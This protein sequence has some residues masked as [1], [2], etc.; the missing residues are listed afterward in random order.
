VVVHGFEIRKELQL[1]SVAP[2]RAVKMTRDPDARIWI[3]LQASQAGELDMWLERLQV[4]ELTRRICLE[5]GGR[6]G[7]YPLRR[8]ILMLI[9]VHTATDGKRDLAY[10]GFLCRKNLLF[11][12][13]QTPIW[14][15]HQLSELEESENWLPD[16]SIAGLVSAVL[17]DLSLES[18][19]HTVGLRSAI[20]ALEERMDRDP[21]SVE[22]EE[23]L[24]VRSEL[25]DLG[26]LINDQMPSLQ[27]LSATDKPF[28][29]L[30]DARDYLNSALANVQAADRSLDRLD[31]RVGALRLGFQM[32][33]QEETN[34]R[35]NILTVLSAIFLPMT[36]LAGIWGMN[37]EGMPELKVPIGYP[38]A[39]GIMALIGSGMFLFF[40]RHGWFD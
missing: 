3:D 27:A 2:E 24:D 10:V 25:L 16:R 15:A 36:F 23:I 40:R 5:A 13:H 30:K 9:P 18:L 35:L 26:A 17:I 19:H 21:G 8:E 1:T 20:V 33:A 6:A 22:A 34:R 14:S 7:F 28:F 39:L 11:T 38:M 32:N 4:R 31:M 37:F 12:F 29:Q